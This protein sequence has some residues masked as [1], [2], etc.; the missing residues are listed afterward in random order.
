MG[1]DIPEEYLYWAGGQIRAAALLKTVSDAVFGEDMAGIKRVGFDFLAQ[2][3]DVDAQVFGFVAVFRAPHALEQL[4]VGDDFARVEHEVVEQVEFGGGKFERLAPPARPGGAGGAGGGG[5]GAGWG[6]G[7]G[8]GG[9]A[10]GRGGPR[11][12]FWGGGFS[13]A[14]TDHALV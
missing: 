8:G 13:P 5:G 9:G 6:G 3:A 2:A 4:P 12:G 11:G 7:G 1:R 14:G 10:G